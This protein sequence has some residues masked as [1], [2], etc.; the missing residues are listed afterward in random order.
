MEEDIII[1]E[2]KVNELSSELILS[3]YVTKE[4]LYKI[5]KEYYKS[6]I[7]SLNIIKKQ[8]EEIM[9]LKLLIIEKDIEIKQKDIM[10]FCL[11]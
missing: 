5:K 11:S 6:L 7:S 9:D 8:K 1:L 4:E 2:E 3:S 10:R